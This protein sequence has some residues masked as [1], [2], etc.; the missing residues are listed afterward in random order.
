MIED[1][2]TAKHVYDVL[3]N[4]RVEISR[5]VDFVK[6]RC[7]E[8]EAEEYKKAVGRALGYLIYEVMEPIRER[9]PSVH[10]DE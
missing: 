10:P 9:H 2:D 5:S 7:T 1:Q 8:A 6:D 4:C 3:L